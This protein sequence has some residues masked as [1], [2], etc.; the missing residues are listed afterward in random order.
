MTP[1]IFPQCMLQEDLPSSAPTACCKPRPFPSWPPPAPP[2]AARLPYWQSNGAQWDDGWALHDPNNSIFSI[3]QRQLC[4]AAAVSSGSFF[5]EFLRGIPTVNFLFP[6]V[7]TVP[8]CPLA[9]YPHP[10]PRANPQTQ[11]DETGGQGVHACPFKILRHVC[12]SRHNMFVSPRH[13]IWNVI[14]TAR[15]QRRV[16]G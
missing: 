16:N 9:A 7:S 6:C 5:G 12:V 11:Q 3:C 13:N 1:T 10:H 2:G 14:I 15:L 8:P 4:V